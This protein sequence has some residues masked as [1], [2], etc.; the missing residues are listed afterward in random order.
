[1]DVLSG[2]MAPILH[3]VRYTLR[4]W[5]ALVVVGALLAGLASASSRQQSQPT[6]SPEPARSSSVPVPADDEPNLTDVQLDCRTNS[7]A[8]L[9]QAAHAWSLGCD[10]RNMMK[11]T[12]STFDLGTGY[13]YQFAH[14]YIGKMALGCVC[15][16][17]TCSLERQEQLIAD[18]EGL[19][20]HRKK[21][22]RDVV[23]HVTRT[24]QSH[25]CLDAALGAKIAQLGF[26]CASSDEVGIQGDSLRRLME[27]IIVAA[28]KDDPAR[29]KEVAKSCWIES[30]TAP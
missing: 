16:T 9:G 22:E 21:L 10:G 11:M 30:T 14:D 17:I 27:R 26:K 19:E 1:M 7:M 29:A 23:Y 12:L 6:Y 4:R 2:V 8:V 28:F 15:K 13:G 3:F 5:R 24:L 25:A 18:L 20:E